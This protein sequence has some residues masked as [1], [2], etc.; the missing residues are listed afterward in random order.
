[1]DLDS[2]A[3]NEVRAVCSPREVAQ[4]ELHLVPAVIE[5]HGHCADERFYPSDV[6]VI[7]RSKPSLD[8]LVIQDCDL[9]R[10]ILLEILNNHDQERQ[11]DTERSLRVIRARDVRCTN[12]GAADLQHARVDIS[13]LDPLD[14]PVLNCKGRMRINSYILCDHTSA[15]MR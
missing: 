11:L 6:L 5:S 12:V 2:K 13:I 14:V 4:V 7:A 1:M 10:E 8:V 9:E 15:V 3:F